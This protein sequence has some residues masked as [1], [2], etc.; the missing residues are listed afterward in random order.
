VDFFAL[1]SVY[2]AVVVNLAHSKRTA[3]VREGTQ[4]MHLYPDGYLCN[5]LGSVPVAVVANLAHSNRTAE[6]RA[7]VYDCCVYT[8]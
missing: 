8:C 3:E 1:R 5:A 7:Q 6:V 4:V 2:V